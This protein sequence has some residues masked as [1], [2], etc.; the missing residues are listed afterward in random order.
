MI[1]AD[2]HNH[3]L[4]SHGLATVGEMF[5]AAQA[6][7]LAWYGFSEHSPLPPGYPCPLYKGDLAVTFPAYAAEV[8]ALRE[9]TAGHA[10]GGQS[11]APRVLLGMEL[12][13]LPVNMP[14]MRD[15]VSRYPFDYIIGGLHF[16][17]DVPVG[18]P[19]SWGPE[20][21]RPQRFARYDAYYEAM[22]GLAASGM[23]DVVAHPDFI[24][25]CCYEDFQAWLALPGSTDRV[26]AALE[27]MRATDTAME[28]SSGGLR[29]PFHEPYPGPAIM[30]L[31]ADLGLTISFGSDA[32]NIQDTG[33]H[34]D[35]LAEYAASYG[36]ARSRI[37]IGRQPLELDF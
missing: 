30:Q 21:E 9:Q 33:S 19:R 4:A 17:G 29:K 27:A 16:V 18:S 34:F 25:V 32:H 1:C 11:G 8:M 15:A 31:A 13:W 26:A 7:K 10:W 3:T 28:V 14:W 12:D 37:C 23:V 6:R 22:Q 35:T 2:I 36:F 20:V 24:K 5:A